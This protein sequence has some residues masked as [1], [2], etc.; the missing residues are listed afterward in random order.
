MISLGSSSPGAA[1]TSRFAYPL[2]TLLRHPF[3]CYFLPFQRSPKFS[4]PLVALLRY[5]FLCDSPA[6]Q[7]SP[8][9]V[10]T[11]QV[12]FSRNDIT[13]SALFM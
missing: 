13:P 7:R 9:A 4:S 5:H 10:K 8:S 3:L 2:L 12:F 6:F 1:E 11:L